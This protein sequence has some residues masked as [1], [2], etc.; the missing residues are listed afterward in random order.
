VV[1]HN[2]DAGLKPSQ[3][4]LGKWQMA[5][6][7]YAAGADFMLANNSFVVEMAVETH[8]A[9]E[10]ALQFGGVAAIAVTGTE[11][12]A[13]QGCEA[14][15]KYAVRQI[16]YLG[17]GVGTSLAS[18]QAARLAQEFGVNPDAIR[19][20]ADSLQVFFLVKAARAARKAQAARQPAQGPP[21]PQK[22]RD[23]L[24][25]IQQ[26]GGN[27]PAGYA[28]GKPWL[29]DG[30]SGT[31]MLPPFDRNGGRITYRE[32]DVNPFRGRGSR[33]LERIV[34]GSDGSGYYTNDHYFSFTQM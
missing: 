27:P 30:R 14:F 31:T 34:I 26:N 24:A 32:Y 6:A 20:G 28:G 29:N 19:I 25:Q 11:L 10:S 18:Q 5:I 23:V 17:I 12:L 1:S 21:M 9:M 15:A 8:D 33:G 2:V 3:A 13:E 16:V 22:A 4:Q 7:S